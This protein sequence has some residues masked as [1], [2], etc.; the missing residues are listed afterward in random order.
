M[1]K[2]HLDELRTAL[3]KRGWRIAEGPGDAVRI[4]A[5]WEMSRANDERSVLIDFDG[6]DG[7]GK[8][9]PLPEAYAC[10]ARGTSHSLYF[11]R[12]GEGGSDARA[13]WQS[14]L[15]SFVMAVD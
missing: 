12:R 10:R 7:N 15:A 3:Q 6:L 1:A 4:S 13:R 9:M 14:E 8:L 2:W 11:S 5:T